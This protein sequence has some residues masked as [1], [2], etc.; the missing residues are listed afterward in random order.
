MFGWVLMLDG[1]GAR[2]RTGGLVDPN[3]AR[4]RAALH[5]DEKR[6]RVRG[7]DVTHNVSPI[8]ADGV[9]CA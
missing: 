5:P 9:R 3:D 4:Y 1:R 7:L 6:P 2:I 8:L